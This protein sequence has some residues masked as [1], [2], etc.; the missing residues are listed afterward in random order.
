MAP[1]KLRYV[2]EFVDRQ[3]RV[4][5]YFRRPGHQ[6]VLLPGLPGSSEFMAAYQAALALVALPPA[7]SKHIPMGSLAA[8][9]AGYFRSASFAN[10]S[11]GSQKLYRVALKPVLAA[12][13]HRR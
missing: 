7:S 1:I 3:G 10:L 6:A 2:N 12:H 5:R 13:G 8:V 9:A 4:R 11:P